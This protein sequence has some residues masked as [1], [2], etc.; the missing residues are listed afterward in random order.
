[1]V[2]LKRVYNKKYTVRIISDYTKE[3]KPIIRKNAH[4]FVQYY[5]IILTDLSVNSIVPWHTS[6]NELQPDAFI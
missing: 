1:M 5:T 4:Q 3:S 2:K 6:F